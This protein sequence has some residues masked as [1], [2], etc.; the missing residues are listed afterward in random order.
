MQ[1]AALR[2]QLRGSSFAGKLVF[3][4]DWEPARDT[5]NAQQGT[6]CCTLASHQPITSTSMVLP[7]S[8]NMQLGALREKQQ[9]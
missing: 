2:Q 6:V 7:A 9:L 3:F 8:P 1:V 4:E 5:K